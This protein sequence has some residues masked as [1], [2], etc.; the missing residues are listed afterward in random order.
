MIKKICL[1]LVI[2]FSLSISSFAHVK[3]EN[4]SITDY[5]GLISEGVKDYV[6]SKN[7]IL[8]DKTGSKIIFVVTQSTDGL[9]ADEY[10]KNL[11]SSWNIEKIGRGNSVF[12]VISPTTSDYGITCG[13]NIKHV[14]T[15][16]IL[17]DKILNDF[18]PYFAS[19]NYD[20]AV[21]SLYNS[22]GKWYEENY[23]DLNLNLDDNV[24]IYISG[25]RI[26]DED[27]KP[28]KL[29]LWIGLGAV[30]ILAVIFFNLKRHIDFKTRQSERRIKRKRSKADIDKLVNS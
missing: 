4:I 12:V 2:I 21:F 26:A 18:E 11:Y 13:K 10:T 17:Y 16:D 1:L 5:C 22:L 14:L 23:I 29:L 19:E 8:F 28:S 6:R 20:A 15:D 27:I 30:G 25:E 9:T 7:T 24:N 3:P